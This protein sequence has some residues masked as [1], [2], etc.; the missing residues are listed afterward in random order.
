MPIVTERKKQIMGKKSNYIIM[1]HL[2]TLLIQSWE[3]VTTSS[4]FPR[5]KRKSFCLGFDLLKEVKRSLKE[6]DAS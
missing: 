2:N 4:L 5:V 3:G 1:T 6:Q